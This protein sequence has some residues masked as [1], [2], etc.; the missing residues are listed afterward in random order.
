MPT[1]YL[2]SNISGEDNVDTGCFGFNNDDTVFPVA[3]LIW[4]LEAFER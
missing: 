2:N 1:E 3:E 4:S